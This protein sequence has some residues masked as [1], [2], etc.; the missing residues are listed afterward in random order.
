MNLRKPFGSFRKRPGL[1]S[2][3]SH[4]YLQRRMINNCATVRNGTIMAVSSVDNVICCLIFKKSYCLQNE[5]VQGPCA[6][7]S[8]FMS[9]ELKIFTPS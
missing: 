8:M 1:L 3:T 2:V 9:V 5:M 6:L 4:K 7:I